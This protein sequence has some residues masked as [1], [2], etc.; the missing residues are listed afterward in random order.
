MSPTQVVHSKEVWR[1]EP[2]LYAVVLLTLDKDLTALAIPENE[3]T[4]QTIQHQLA[5]A[6]LSIV[7]SFPKDHVHVLPSVEHAVNIVKG[8]SKSSPVGVLVS[9]SLHLVGGMIEVAGL[10]DVAL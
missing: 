7:P 6:W 1:N 3:L 9:G 4:E 5:D 2:R 8:L 10:A